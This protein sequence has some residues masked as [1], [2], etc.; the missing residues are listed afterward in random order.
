M[1]P[2]IDIALN[3]FSG[4]ELDVDAKR[5]NGE[6][7]LTGARTATNWRILNSRKL[8]NR[9]GRRALFL[10]SGRIDEVL[11]SP[12]NKFFLQFGSG[13]PNG[14]LTVYDT[15]GTLLFGPVGGFNWND[16][17]VKSIV[18]CQDNLKNIYIFFPGQIPQVLTWNGVSTWSIAPYAETVTAGNQ[19]RTFFYRISPKNVTM[20]P[21]AATGSGVLCTFSA[22]MNLTAGH[23]GT[24]LRYV[25]RQVLITAVADPTHAT[26]TIQETL[27]P[28][29]QL[30]FGA[31]DPRP[32]FNVGDIVIGGTTGAKGIVTATAIGNISV[33]LLTVSLTQNAAVGGGIGT[34][35]QD[36]TLGFSSTEAVTGPG[37]S[38]TLTA[39]AALAP[40]AVTFWDD[41]VMNALRG[42][43]ASG[44]FDQGRLGM[45]NFPSV[46]GAIGWSAIGLPNDI[47]VDGTTSAAIFELAP[48]RSQVLYVVPGAEGSE[49]VF[50]DN[51]VYYIPISINNPLKP[52][53]VAFNQISGDGCYP[54]QPRA[55]GTAVVFLAAGGLRVSAIVAIGQTNR[56]Y[57]L[58]NLTELHSHLLR[59]P[60][61]IAIPS[62]DAAF[63]ERY[64]YVLNNDGTVAVG[65][66]TLD[67]QQQLKGAVGWLLWSG[68][69]AIQWISA[70]DA[71]VTMVT[72]YVPNGVVAK[73]V[74]QVDRSTDTKMFLD[75]AIFVNLIPSGLTPPGGKGPFWWIPLGSVFLMD[76]SSRP[77]GLYQIDAN[78]F[79]I[80]QFTGGENLLAP[81]LVGGQ[82]W[83]ST[84]LPIIPHAP[85]GSDSQQRMRRRRVIKANITVQQSTG[86]TFGTSRV[87]AYNIDDDA[88]LPPISRET[89][90][91]FRPRGRSYDPNIALIKDT[92][93]PL[94][95]VEVGMEVTV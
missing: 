50:C 35:S 54:V 30:T 28:G 27:P 95:I 60:I 69:G 9:P 81:T 64:A 40:Q 59:S 43:P 45:C 17:T 1:I 58:A 13:V 31:I 53:S 3:D 88:T 65:K 29:Q 94:I 38:L 5:M 72:I 71:D 49:M 34:K 93:G 46:P 7:A 14:V 89:S 77:L 15:A 84:Y 24:R 22:G 91:Q 85:P 80:P 90:Y 63:S 25:N 55:A 67:E 66:Y 44:F 52:G 61:A 11:M 74:E 12:G 41:E 37:G 32:I 4:G 18:W 56:P 82:M 76:Q 39:V 23:I 36:I 83:T 6:V 87:P 33:Q 10:Q 8:S 2:K 42:W 75:G 47:Y 21:A 48:N 92:P 68:P 26:I 62:A 79:I 16:D 70:L 78:G 86:F 73:V 57:D 20:L 51:R 19:K